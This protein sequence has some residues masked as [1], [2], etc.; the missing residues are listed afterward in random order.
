ME[1][2]L[3]KQEDLTSIGT[4]M[5]RCRLDQ[6]LS[7]KKKIYAIDWL[8]NSSGSDT[9]KISEHLKMK[10]GFDVMQKNWLQFKI[11]K[12]GYLADLPYGKKAIGTK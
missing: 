1:K 12:F 5:G 8:C 7:K 11:R 6:S 3:G 9:E 10:V 2:A 4:L